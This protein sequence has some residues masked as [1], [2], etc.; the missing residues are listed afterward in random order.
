MPQWWDPFGALVAGLHCSGGTP[1]YLLPTLSVCC[2]GCQKQ[3]GYPK[4]ARPLMSLIYCV[5]WPHP[6]T[7][8]QVCRFLHE[9]QHV[10]I[11]GMHKTAQSGLGW[12]VV[13]QYVGMA[14]GGTICWDG[15]LL[16]PQQNWCSLFTC[17]LWCFGAGLL[18]CV[19]CFFQ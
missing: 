17:T 11:W 5:L 4:G 10:L 8:T 1:Q 9:V 3:C 2:H 6:C 7:R 13:A 18:R 16:A 14:C 15:S 12:H 19:G